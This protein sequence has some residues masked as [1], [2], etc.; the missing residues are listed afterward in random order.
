MTTDEDTGTQTAE[1][2]RSSIEDLLD[3]DED[4]E[5]GF[6]DDT[7]E[8][9]ETPIGAHNLCLNPGREE[10]PRNPLCPVCEAEIRPISSKHERRFVCDCEQLWQF[11]F[12]PKD[13]DLDD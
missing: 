13:G 5:P 2:E 11:K 10:A 7:Y 4:D 6:L 12:Q 9:V 8:L 1:T 3:S